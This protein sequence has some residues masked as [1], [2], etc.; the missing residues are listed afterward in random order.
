MR[1]RLRTL[2]IATAVLPPLMACLWHFGSVIIGLCIA[3][4]ILLLV[5]A[6]PAAMVA[7]PVALLALVFSN[8]ADTLL[9]FGR[10]PD[11]RQ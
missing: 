11:N 9:Y 6:V 3:I 8:I 7:L 1:Y 2:V 5:A 10:H 4:P